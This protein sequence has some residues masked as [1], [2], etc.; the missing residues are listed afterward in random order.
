MELLVRELECS[1][2]QMFKFTSDVSSVHLPSLHLTYL[3]NIHLKAIPVFPFPSSNKLH[4]LCFSIL[5][6]TP[7]IYT[8]LPV[9]I[10]SFSLL[11]QPS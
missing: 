9:Q 3:S 11:L 10:H 5:T 6:V 4:L 1:V 7:V 8:V 2:Q